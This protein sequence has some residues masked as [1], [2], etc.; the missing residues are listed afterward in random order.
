MYALRS[1]TTQPDESAVLY[2]S[3]KEPLAA[4][5]VLA[6]NPAARTMSRLVMHED[7]YPRLIAGQQFSSSEFALLLPLFTSYPDYCPFEDFLAGHLYHST[8]EE[9]IARCRDRL[10][11]AL[12][13]GTW[14]Q[15]TAPLRGIISRL[16]VKVR[17]LG[18]EMTAIYKTGYLL[19]A[20][21]HTYLAVVKAPAEGHPLRHLLHGFLP[22][23]HLLAYNSTLRLLSYLTVE[24]GNPRL[25]L[26]AELTLL[27]ERVLL[28][29]LEVAPG[30]CSDEVI[31]A[32]YTYG[33][34]DEQTLARAA[35]RLREATNMGTWDYA[36]RPVRNSMS[37]AR[38][39]VSA[40]GIAL[41]SILGT[42]YMA[43]WVGS[44]LLQRNKGGL[45]HGRHR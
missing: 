25:F 4:H 8:S 20:I 6:L 3:P 31:L 44:Q 39:K 28:P 34:T 37:R 27:E 5:E 24:Q 13:S 30:Y 32:N 36:M 35:H 12:D 9:N 17:E 33:E 10:Q 26:E 42:G 45:H 19:Q 2:R 21:G 18:V 16:H 43:T 22:Q 23:G 15:E 38:R 40:M 29:V 11:T 41:P 14:Q 1:T 7:G